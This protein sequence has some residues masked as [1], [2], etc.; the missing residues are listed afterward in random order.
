MRFRRSVSV[1]FCAALLLP[2]SAFAAPRAEQNTQM[3]PAVPG[4]DA[5]AQ[6]NVDAQNALAALAK[7]NQGDSTDERAAL[8]AQGTFS[9]IY[10]NTSASDEGKGKYI[11]TWDSQNVLTVWKENGQ[12]IQVWTYNLNNDTVGYTTITPSGRT[13]ED[14]APGDSRYSQGIKEMKNQVS[15][16]LHAKIITVPASRTK[17]ETALAFLTARIAEL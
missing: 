1:F 14:Y 3:P 8:I 10:D 17:L 9:Q 4:F 2:A 12:H 5:K 16:L 13:H 6:N 15:Q 11:A 7:K